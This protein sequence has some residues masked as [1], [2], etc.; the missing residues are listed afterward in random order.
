MDEVVIRPRAG[1]APDRV[2][3]RFMLGLLP[4]VAAGIVR[5]LRSGLSTGAWTIAAFAALVSVVALLRADFFA[6]TSVRVADDVIRRTGYFGRTATCSRAAVA[7]VMLVTLGT[8]RFGAIPAKWLL[9]LDARGEPVLRAYAE[10]YSSDQLAQLEQTL[11][12]PWDSP[13]EIRTFA[14]MRRDIPRSFPWALAHVWL[15][16]WGAFFILIAVVMV[17][18]GH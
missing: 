9:F 15:T 17:V 2:R 5:A 16:T 6:Q 18:A 11:D 3:W 7:R 8:S 13:S 12:V 1:G 4:L 14:Q 10:Y